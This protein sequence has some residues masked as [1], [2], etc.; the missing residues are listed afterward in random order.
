MRHSWGVTLPLLVLTV[1]LVASTL[2][3]SWVSVKNREFTENIARIDRNR[4]ADAE[5]YRMQLEDFLN[6]TCTHGADRGEVI[7]TVLKEVRKRAILRGDMQAA[8]QY[9]DAIVALRRVAEQCFA[10]V[11]TTPP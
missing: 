7:V 1:A 2:I 8:R 11:P 10:T 6:H 3:S 9:A 4:A 5:L